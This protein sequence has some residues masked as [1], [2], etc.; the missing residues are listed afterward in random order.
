MC[1]LISRFAGATG[2]EHGEKIADQF[3]PWGSAAVSWRVDDY[4]VHQGAGRLEGV[5]R[6]AGGQGVMKRRGP[7]AVDLGQIRVQRRDGLAP[8]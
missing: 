7:L 4:A 3:H 1:V 6:I 5:G 2:P 8:L